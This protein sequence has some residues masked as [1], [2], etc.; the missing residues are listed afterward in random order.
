MSEGFE[1]TQ[2][3]TVKEYG[4]DTVER[5]HQT[6]E[7]TEDGEQHDAALCNLCGALMEP[8]LTEVRKDG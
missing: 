4:P 1:C 3:S 6:V 2:C 8:Y 5:L 7:V